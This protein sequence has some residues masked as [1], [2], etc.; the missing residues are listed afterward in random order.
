MTIRAQQ[1]GT[2][3]LLI[4]ALVAALLAGLVA[5]GWA[6]G[7]AHAVGT[8]SQ[9]RYMAPHCVT[10]GTCIKTKTGKLG[11]DAG[12]GHIRTASQGNSVGGSSYTA[13]AALG[14]DSGGGH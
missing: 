13:D 6:T 5:V 14:G 4:L 1:S 10:A 9:P 12:G 7:A 3:L 11:G 2:R 8:G